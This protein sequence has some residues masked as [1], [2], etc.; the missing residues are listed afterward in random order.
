MVATGSASKGRRVS[1]KNATPEVDP[2]IDLDESLDPDDP[3][4]ADDETEQ[5]EWGLALDNLA[6]QQ[7]PATVPVDAVSEMINAAV[8]AAL[9]KFSAEVDQKVEQK[10]KQN[11]ATPLIADTSLQYVPPAKFKKHYR[12]DVAP[13]L[14]IQELDMSSLDRDDRP[15]SNPISGRWIQFRSGHLH[16]NSDNVI[17]QI[18]YMMNRDMYAHDGEETV[19]GNPSIY[20]DDGADIYRCAQGCTDFIT[21]S[22]A[23]WKAHMRS[24]HGVS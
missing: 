14:K 4:F 10:I 3:D 17:R 8:A 7:P 22:K 18:D 11:Q 9:N 23:S 5:G 6:P 2:V 15:Q 21:A 24:V 16:T 20:E 12:N 19:G 13:N 1:T